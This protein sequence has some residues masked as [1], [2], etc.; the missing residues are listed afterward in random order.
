MGESKHAAPSQPPYSTARVTGA[1]LSGS[2][3]D[4]PV[5]GL[6]CYGTSYAR[7]LRWTSD[8]IVIGSDS[9]CDLP[10]SD[11][12]VSRRHAVLTRDSGRVVVTDANSTNGTHHEGVR[13][14][15]FQLSPG[16]H[17]AVG[18]VHLVATNER[19][20]AA[21][22]RLGRFLGFGEAY[23]ER[24]DRAHFAA[25]HR[26]HVAILEPRGGGGV[27]LARLLHATAPGETWPFVVTEQR[28]AD[29]V[30][31]QLG[32]LRRARLGTLAVPVEHWPR[33]PGPLT[34]ALVKGTHGARLVLI[35]PAGRSLESLL[36][37]ELMQLTVAVVLPSLKERFSGAAGD[38]ER[39]RL[40]DAVVGEQSAAIGAAGQLLSAAD[41]AALR[42]YD[43]PDGHDELDQ[44]VARLLL[45]RQLG[46]EQAAMRLGIRGTALSN[47]FIRRGLTLARRR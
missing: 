2:L 36:G 38:L 47:W 1:E 25:T 16:A 22:A 43:W 10:I 18:R 26:R 42:G 28:L 34:A 35:V 9:S 45:W 30:P 15:T 14:S 12:T 46:Q 5:T 40:L 37:A 20:E 19:V 23:Q 29:S 27:G 44:G 39:S 8:S 17:F 6:R 41:V 13:Q 21:R 32:T 33:Q 24:V 7:P 31:E 4:E 3:A 11:P